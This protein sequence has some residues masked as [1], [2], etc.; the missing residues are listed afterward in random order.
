MTYNSNDGNIH[1]NFHSLCK[2][3]AYIYMTVISN[4][5]YYCCINKGQQENFLV[6][7]WVP[8]EII[9]YRSQ[10]LRVNLSLVKFKVS[11]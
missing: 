9:H 8:N 10:S 7:D 6:M 5:I 1:L 2:Q 3:Y 4:E 11:S